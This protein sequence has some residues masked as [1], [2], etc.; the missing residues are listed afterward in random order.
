MRLLKARGAALLCLVLLT[1]LAHAGAAQT[2][3]TARVGAAE[4]DL[5]GTGWSGI[6]GAQ[7]EHRLTSWLRVE[8]GS[9]LFW[10]A[11]QLGDRVVMLLPEAGLAFQGPGF[12]PFHLGFGLGRSLTV[13]GRQLDALTLYG[14]LGLSLSVNDT[15]RVG[16]EFRLRF[17]DPFVGGVGGITVAVTRRLGA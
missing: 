5:A 13:Q 9:G 15:W 1:G 12:L 7:V 10:Y 8:A 11:P 6:V 4:Y 3:L 14:A 17:I 2:S 16:P